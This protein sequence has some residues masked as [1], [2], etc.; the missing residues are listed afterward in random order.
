[1]SLFLSL[2]AAIVVFAVYV[3]YPFQ[4]EHVCKKA[5]TPKNGKL[6]YAYKDYCEQLYPVYASFA[7]QSNQ[8][9]KAVVAF[10]GV[11]LLLNSLFCIAGIILM[12][13]KRK[14]TVEGGPG[15]LHATG[16]EL[17][18]KISKRFFEKSSQ[19]QNQPPPEKPSVASTTT[20]QP[21][22]LKPSTKA[23]TKNTPAVKSSS[24]T[25]TTRR[26]RPAKSGTAKPSS[27]MK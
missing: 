26:P 12:A 6:S 25:S 10:F 2:L 27:L 14:D 17:V 16:E 1:M 19:T 3:I 23:V 8:T 4:M 7:T 18:Q 24:T 13:R 9:L 5:Y 21:P 22:P 20:S 15:I 11:M